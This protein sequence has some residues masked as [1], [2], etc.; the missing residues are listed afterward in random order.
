VEGGAAADLVLLDRPW[1]RARERLS[2]EPVEATLCAGRV[3]WQRGAGG[4]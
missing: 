2:R 3:V 4:A 1:A